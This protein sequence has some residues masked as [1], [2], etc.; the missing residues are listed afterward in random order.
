V[1]AGVP[2]QQF[3]VLRVSESQDPGTTGTGALAGALGLDDP[4][5][6]L[7]LS[8]H[9]SE[10]DYAHPVIRTGFEQLRKMLDGTYDASTPFMQHVVDDGG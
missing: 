3:N 1:S 6:M 8:G 9:G 4:N 7:R 10:A 2:V 5:T